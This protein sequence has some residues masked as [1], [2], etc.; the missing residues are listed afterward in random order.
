VSEDIR[1]GSINC[2]RIREMKATACPGRMGSKKPTK[3][4]TS[5]M[6]PSANNITSKIKMLL[7]A[8]I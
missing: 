4:T 6:N 3:P 7:I 5:R 2:N 8:K 1:G